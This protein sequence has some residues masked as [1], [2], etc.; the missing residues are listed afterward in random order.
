MRVCVRER[1]KK[2]GGGEREADRLGVRGLGMKRAFKCVCVSREK[3]ESNSW[4]LIRYKLQMILS[5]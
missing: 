3:Q 5:E 1:E 2:K 4:F